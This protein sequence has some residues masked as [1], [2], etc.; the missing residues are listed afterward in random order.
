MLDVLARVTVSCFTASYGVG[1]LME[2]W[3]LVQPRPILRY[4]AIGFGAAGALA[5]LLFVCFNPLPLGS[6]AGSFLLLSL[7]LAVFYVYGS[8]HHHRLAWGTFVL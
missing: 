7:I 5:Q 4:L 6:P 2:L 8:I 1:L 3:H